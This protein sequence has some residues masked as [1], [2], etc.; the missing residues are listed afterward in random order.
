MNTQHFVGTLTISHRLLK[1]FAIL[2]CNV[3]FIGATFAVPAYRGWQQ[4]TLTDGTPITVRQVGD[5]FYHYWETEDGKIAIMQ[6][7]GKFVIQDENAPTTEQFKSLRKAS[8]RMPGAVIKKNY[9]AIQPTKLLVILVNF[10]DKSMKT[11]HN[12][13][14]FD[15]LLNGSFPSVQD[16]FKQSSGNTYV[17]QFDVFGPYTL[18]RNMAYYGSNDSGGNDEHP[19]QMVVDACAKAY[20]DGCN[21]ANY[22]TNGDNK[23]DNIYVIYAGYGEAAGAPANTI[24]PHSWEIYS[25]NVSGTLKY[26]GKTLGHYACS[27]ELSGKSGSNSDGVGTFAHEFSHVIGLPDYYDTDYGTNSDNLVTPGE[28]T[29]MDQ[30]SYNG[31]GMYPPLYSIY[32]KYFM[33]WTM[34]KFLAKDE[35]KNV[36]MTTTWNDAYQITGGASRVACTNTS[37]VYYIENRQKSGYDQYLPGHGMVVWKVQYNS[38]RWNNN[39]LNNTAGTLRYTIVPADGKTKNYG[40]AADPFPGSK[41]KKTYTPFT[42]CALTDITE[43]SGNINFK[44]NGGEIKTTWEYV[45]YGENCTYPADGEITKNAALN[46][47]ITPNS[48]YSLADAACWDVQMGG[49]SLTYGTDFTYNAGTNTFSIASVTGDVEIIMSAG[50]PITW[51]D[52]GS[53]HATNV[54]AEGKITLPAAPSNCSSSRQFVG[55]CTNSTYKSA[56]TPPT[57]A[58]TGDDYS[59]SDYYAVYADVSGGG[60]ASATYTFSDKSWSASPS[61]WTSGKDGNGYS[62]NGVQVTAG[63][64]GANATCPTSYSD[65]STITVSY[66]TNASSGAGSIKMTVDGNDVSESVTSTGGTTARDLEFNF[67]AIKPTGKPKITVNCSTN[68]IYVCGVT[69]NYG[70]A[71]YSGFSTD[72]TAPDPCALSSISL[73]TSSVTKAFTV[74]DAFNSDGLVVTANYSNCSSKTVTPTSVSTPDMGSAGNKTVTVTYTESAVTKTETYQITVSAA[75][76]YAIRFF[77]GTTKLKEESLIMGATATPPSV[78]DCDEYEFVGWWT[79]TLATSNT[80][81]ETWITNFTV[82]CAQDYYAVFSH[83]DG[84]GGG[85]TSGSKTFAFST[86]A[87][88]KGWENS[89]AYTSVEISPV[90]INANGG[91]N[92]GKWYT[93]SGGSWRMYSGGTVVVTVDGGD[94]T[95]V[96]SS[97]TCTFTIDDSGTYA[98]A[99]FSPSARTDFTSITVNYTTGGGSTTYYTTTK[100]CTI[101]TEVTVKFDANGGEG[102]MTD[103]TID[104]NTAT[105]LKVNTFE[106]TGY[107][108]LGWATSSTGTKVYDDEEEVTLTKKTTTLYALWE[109]NSWKLYFT[110]PSGATSVTA[111]GETSSPLTIEYGETVTIIITPDAEHVFGTITA[112]GGAV[113]SGDGTTRT[114]TMPDNDVALSI[115]MNSKP[116]YTIRFLNLGEVISSQSIIEGQAAVKPA[117]PTACDGYTFVGWWTAEL[118]TTNTSS[119][120]W[121]TDFTATQDQDYYAAYSHNEGGSGGGSPV[122]KTM[123]SFDAI[124]GNVDN[125]ANISY[126]AAQGDA[127][128]APAVNSNEIRIYQNGG[129]LTVTANNSKKITNVTIGSSMVTSITYSIDGGAAS[130]DQ[131]I[132]AGGTFPLSDL[133]AS[134][135][136]YT[137]TGTDKNHRL[138]LNYLSVTYTTG[139][140]SSTTYYTTAPNCTPCLTKVTLTKGTESH[141]TFTL[142]KANGEHNNCTS[143]FVVSV[144]DINPDANYYCTG[145]T[146]TGDNYEVNGPDILG[147]Y[148]VTYTKGNSIT[149]TIIANFALIPSYTVTWSANGDDSNQSTYYVGDAIEFPST[150]TGCDGKVFIGWSAS[151]VAETD[152]KPALVT[153]A[154]MPAHDVT[155]YAVFAEET[156][157]GGD[158]TYNLLEDPDDFESGKDYVIAVYYGYDYALFATVTGSYYLKGEYINIPSSNAISTSDANMIWKITTEATGQ[159]SLYNEDTHMYAYLYQS[160]GYYDLGLRSTKYNWNFSYTQPSGYYPRFTF[161]AP[162]VTGYSMVW[163][164]TNERYAAKTSGDGNI[165]LYKKTG[166]TSYSGYTT[167]CVPC[168]TKV[169]LT[170]GDEVNGTFTLDK[171]DGIYNNCTSNFV[172]TV[173]DIT[174]ATGYYCSGVTATGGNSTV[175][176]PDGSGNYTVTY[177]K[178]NNITSTITAG[179]ESL[180]T[181]TVTWSSNGDES[182]TASYHEGDPIVFPS[183]A[184]GCEGKDF[185][186]W[187]AAEVA[188]TDTKPTLVTS[189]TMPSHN[190]TYYAVFAEEATGGSVTWSK[191]ES[192]SAITDGTYVIESN[193]YA[194]PSTTT[195]AS[196]VWNSTYAL[197]ISDGKITSTVAADMKWSITVAMS[198]TDYVA[199]IKNA[200][201]NYLYCTSA[202]A[203]LRVGGTADTWTLETNPTAPHFAM[204][205]QNNGRYCAIYSAGTDWRSYSSADHTNYADGGKLHFYKS[206]A[207]YKGYTTFCGASIS[208]QNVGWITAA[209]GQKVKRVIEV[210]AKNFDDPATL[211]ATCANSHFNVSLSATDVPAGATGL[212]TNLTVEYTPTDFGGK[213]ENVEIVLTAGDKTKTIKV[214]GRSLP[215]EFV[216]IAK[217]SSEWYAVPANMNSGSKAYD[218]VV[219]IPNTEPPTFVSVAPSTVIYRL[220]SI[221]DTRYNDA[222]NCVLLVGNGDKCLWANGSSGTTGIYNNN[223]VASASSGHDEWL[224]ATE[225][226]AQY[227]ISNPAHPDAADGRRLANGGTGG[228][229]FGLYKEATVF[230]IVPVG[231]SSQP[232]DVHV[233]AKRVDAT[234]SWV[235]NA[236]SVTIDVYTNETMTE[237][238]LSATATSSPF[239]FTGL[240]ETTDYWFKLT[241]GSASDCGVDGQFRTSGPI[242]DITEWKED[243]VVLFIDKG[244]INPVIVIDGQEEHGSITGGGGTAT[245]LFFAK[246]FE[247]YGSMKLLSI[248]NGTPNAISLANYKFIDRHAGGD[249]S[250][251]GGD[252]EYELSSLGSIQAGQEIIFFTRPSEDEVAD[253]SNTFL[254]EK[255]NN[256]SS[257]ESNPR[258]IECATDKFVNKKIT[259][260][261]NDALLLKK[262]DDIIDVI[263]SL[264]TPGKSDNCRNEDAWAGTVKN[265]D[266]GKKPSDPAFVEFFKASSKHPSTK[267]DSIALLKAFGIDLDNDDIS[268]YT[269]RCILFRDNRVT[270]GDSAVSMNTEGDFKTFTTHV[271]S[272]TTY[273]SEWYGR[274]VCMTNAMKT[275]AGVTNDGKPTCNSYQD[276]ANMD[277]N[278]YYI[279]YTSH[280]EPGQTLDHYTHDDETHLYT[281]P[282]DNLSNYTCLNIRFQLKKDGEVL[283][284]EAQQVPIIVSGSRTTKDD[285]FSKLVIDQE[286]HQPSYSYSVERCKTCNVVVLAG[287]KLTKAADDD[288]L[289]VP[290]V[291]NVKIYPTGQLIVPE[292][293]EY[294]IKSL[295]LRRQEDDVASAKIEGTLNVQETNA[296][297]LD[298]RIDPSNWHYITLPF[299]CN[300]SDIRFANEEETAIPQIGTDFLLCS[301]D[302]EH[303]AA[304]QSTSWKDL[305]STDVLKMGI[306]YI[307]ALPGDGKVQREFRF[308]MANTVLTK[309]KDDKLIENLHAWGGL[310]TELRPNH[311]GWNLVGNPYMMYY[312]LQDMTTPLSAGTLMHDPAEEPWEGHWVIKDGTGEDAITPLYYIVVPKDNG[313]SEYEQTTIGGYDMPPFTS[314]FVQIGGDPAVNKGIEF[315]AD[316]KEDV[317]SFVIRRNT[318]EEVDNHEVWFGVDLINADGESDETTL[319]MSDKFTNDYDMMRD[320]VKMRGTYYNYYTKPVLA[321]RNNEG[322]MA[323]NALPDSTAALGVPLNF[324]AARDGQ[325]RFAVSANYSLD[326]VKEAY[327]YDKE[328]TDNKW[329]NLL[330]DDYVFDTKRGDNTSRFLISVR[331]ER[332][333]PEIVTSLDNINR[334][335]TLTTL[336]RTL[337]VSG[338]NKEADIYVYDVSGKLLNMG[339]H[340]ASA[341]GIYR[342]TVD[343]PG[344]YFVRVKT[345]DEQQT[346]ETVVY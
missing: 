258:W 327:L 224:L 288:P 26:N 39:D 245:E 110:T 326:E 154:T 163:D 33:G 247:G 25:S 144:S 339:R 189:A 300:V 137:C 108:F 244:D 212:T 230:Y 242:I 302:G 268:I 324:Y 22:D 175:S 95:S 11:A 197:T 10:S 252:T 238:H 61:D 181:Y 264:G 254:N 103:Q 23:V 179:F 62:N 114:F 307:F 13:A 35:V 279:D 233:S 149:S 80:T 311:K 4:R 272:G 283:T 123:S 18:D 86:I 82:S 219:V 24:W 345:V 209:K 240:T 6:D 265:M 119:K 346:L 168:L 193:G 7:N 9:G 306:G 120:T 289:D 100:D 52:K 336:N 341:E 211:S 317:P 205:D 174:P 66:C 287:A 65:I 74:G 180:P 70:S 178:E 113:L 112:T 107:T 281:I 37:T 285:M 253:C 131:A 227:T 176:G 40:D 164:D 184:T 104:Y 266:K 155:Y 72:C 282:I 277:Y 122:T 67:S 323:F 298:I 173:S 194:L 121:I 236:S 60:S 85:S 305:T 57:Y 41:S 234:F 51:H 31:S 228:T 330:A 135:V 87:S 58:K 84:G 30:G 182:S 187:S 96:T 150:A 304:T 221:A 32:D 54:A 116:S 237:G 36:T 316:R 276:I 162:D 12:N 223:D 344:V 225:D 158:V 14:F 263:G 118:A 318:A 267:A 249:A 292:G 38:T 88:E 275:E 139:G 133:N 153:S 226:G 192:L 239:V 196:P 53:T 34:P 257:A 301:Y 215:E 293:R 83:T 186:G 299:D 216:I 251:Y 210:S 312:D 157:S 167:S 222:G 81:A 250:A 134:S 49:S 101:P 333:Q 202:N 141:G 195:S 241:P 79:S 129:T 50:H 170:K 146:A 99:S 343:N 232:Q 97:P 1:L 319:L 315:E 206:T 290:E 188:E 280:I 78:D 142:D 90:T 294:T 43:S 185:I 8:K 45:L 128:T 201:G 115:T 259:F 165:Y 200:S 166:G 3:L 172:V 291:A 199:T 191:V 235:S 270:S 313:M 130:S 15:N 71:S 152:T 2:L 29:L 231:C 132:S 332:K 28:W 138:Y 69:I 64:T 91:G 308:P 255:V 44:Y 296:T 126:E 140:G 229:Q 262:G 274:S 19:D 286:T 322:E 143:N 5:E 151:T 17:P 46:L 295:S 73:N 63:T 329:H 321:S 156:E 94:V 161:G 136:L 260:N 76:T 111:N 124:S 177:T 217:K 92:N 335:L 117:N 21:F 340:R 169:T 55:W 256:H 16:Y 246:Y 243:G 314:Y 109:K 271:E 278:E 208:A 203:G 273:K 269:A 338:L 342:T 48:G 190:V 148:T 309:E 98:T 59:V 106:R 145:V 147:N 56:D 42:G 105:A 159:V 214:N 20:A 320:L 171:A 284:E 328:N 334:Q 204:Y 125:D 183:T 337:I 47:T 68:S 248:F 220:H 218:G 77:D 89:Q 102:T 325:Y 127:S 331:V 213:E 297:Y 75:T 93:S 310:D 207:S 198:G 27:A 261:G 160:G 303:R